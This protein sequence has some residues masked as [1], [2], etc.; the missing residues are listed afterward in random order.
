MCNFCKPTLNKKMDPSE[1]TRIISESILKGG[2]DGALDKLAE[3]YA[4][5]GL[6]TPITRGL[7]TG[8]FAYGLIVLM[9][10]A[11]WYHSNGA[12]KPSSLFSDRPDAVA[13]GPEMVA[14]LVG[15]I[16]AGF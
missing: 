1:P 5:F 15:I 4:A 2:G 12:K 16:A 7:A 13:L 3:A 8:G 6:R 10:P 11:Y 14:A 9:K